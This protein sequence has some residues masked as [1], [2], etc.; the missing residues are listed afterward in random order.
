MSRF[1]HSLV[2]AYVFSKKKKQI[3][4]RKTL[5]IHSR[6]RVFGCSD[7]CSEFHPM[8]SF[9]ARATLV[10][11]RNCG[12]Q[13]LLN[14]ILRC[15]MHKSRRN[16]NLLQ[17][18]IFLF[19]FEVSADFY[20]ICQKSAQMTWSRMWPI[21]TPHDVM[22]NI[23]SIFTKHRV[24]FQIADLTQPPTPNSEWLHFRMVPRYLWSRKH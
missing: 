21:Q 1:S 14:F 7:H 17:L 19:D 20:A 9:L 16:K 6:Y 11:F 8:T 5:Q 22:K 10:W 3:K 13:K 18:K 23:F 2:V 15:F 24:E 12:K 4:I